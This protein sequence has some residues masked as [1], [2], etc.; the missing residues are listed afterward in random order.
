MSRTKKPKDEKWVIVVPPSI[1]FEGYMMQCITLG[2]TEKKCIERA[3][4][5]GAKESD[6]KLYLSTTNRPH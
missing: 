4:Q 3:R 2:Y 5:L 6:I 1:Y